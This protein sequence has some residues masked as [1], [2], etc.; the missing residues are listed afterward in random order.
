MGEHL[1]EDALWQRMLAA[2]E[3]VP[4]MHLHDLDCL[5]RFVSACFVVMRTNLTWAELGCLVP[6][7]EAAKRRLILLGFC[8]CPAL[9]VEAGDLAGTG[10]PLKA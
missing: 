7:A 2:L 6:S 8:G 9:C 1:I 4:Y 5:H 10:N 3:T